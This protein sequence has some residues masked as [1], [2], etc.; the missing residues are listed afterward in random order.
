M[1]ACDGK[2]YTPSPPS[3]RNSQT[4]SPSLIPADGWEAMCAG[5]VCKN[6]GPANRKSGRNGRKTLAA[7]IK[8]GQAHKQVESG[9]HSGR[10]GRRRGGF[11]KASAH[12]ILLPR[13]SD[14]SYI[15]PTHVY[16][17]AW[18]GKQF[19]A[20]PAGGGRHS[21][22]NGLGRLQNLRFC[23][24]KIAVQSQPGGGD[25]GR[26]AEAGAGATRII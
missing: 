12:G 17:F 7:L 21:L 11:K 23:C 26:C 5:N 2:N 8:I 13:Q 24:L 19:D 15:H 20:G 4:L 1:T 6:K 10:I 25:G 9:G 16:C 22:P 3:M 18:A 14:S